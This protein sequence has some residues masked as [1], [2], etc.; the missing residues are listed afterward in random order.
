MYTGGLGCARC[1]S[2]EPCLAGL[3]SLGA[4][5][6]LDVMPVIGG[7]S[8]GLVREA[9][10]NAT[11]EAGRDPA[12][13]AAFTG[14]YKARYG[15][16]PPTSAGNIPLLITNSW[17]GSTDL[18]AALI[19]LVQKYGGRCS[20][21]DY[22]NGWTPV[23]TGGT[24]PTPPGDDPGNS[25]WTLPAGYTPAPGQPAAGSTGG[26]AFPGGSTAT[27]GSGLPSVGGVNVLWLVAGGLVAW[28]LFG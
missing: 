7:P 9:V 6:G 4:A 11:T 1:Q 12:D 28:K 3:G 14:L 15:S 17:N 23:V 5:S 13:W 21:H 27:S 22:C 24:G 26:N 10:D 20:G 16:N 2:G 19:Y 8:V 25:T 18:R